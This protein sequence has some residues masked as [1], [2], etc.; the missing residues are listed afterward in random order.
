MSF[1]LSFPCSSPGYS[2]D[3]A[4]WGQSREVT[5]LSLLANSLLMQPRVLVAFWAERTHCLLMLTFSSSS[6]SPQDSFSALSDQPVFMLSISPN[7]VQHFA[8]H[9]VKLPVVCM[10]STLNGT[11]SLFPLCVFL[12]FPALGKPVH[13]FL[14]FKAENVIA[15]CHNNC[16]RLT[17]VESSKSPGASQKVFENS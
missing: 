9:I 15:H 6:P 16:K 11:P 14:I 1:F 4:S 8:L 10:D 5:S 17:S 13:Y 3:G 7:E 2:T 12:Y